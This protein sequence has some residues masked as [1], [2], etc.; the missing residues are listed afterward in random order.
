MT[1]NV[2]SHIRKISFWIVSLSIYAQPLWA[3]GSLADSLKMDSLYRIRE[4]T[5]TANRL[6]KEVV[7]VQ[8]L[9][10]DALKQLSAHSVADAVRYFSGVQVK[11]YGGI[12]GLKTVNIRSMG[13][14]HVGVFYDGVELGNAQNGVVDLG[15]F[16]LENMEA[17]SQIGRAHV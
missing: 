9:E 16:S 12:G 1:L 5:V 15:R 8:T 17:V 11:D 7:P 3:E 6:Q 4:V 2:I 10:G 13:S 14:H